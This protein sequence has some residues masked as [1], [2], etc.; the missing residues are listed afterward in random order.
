MGVRVLCQQLRD[1]SKELQVSTESYEVLI[2]IYR[3]RYWNKQILVLFSYV[4]NSEMLAML[5][6]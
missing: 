2:V 5:Q 4:V 6:M 1:I 3:S